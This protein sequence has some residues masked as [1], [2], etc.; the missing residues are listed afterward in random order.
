VCATAPGGA[1]VCDTDGHEIGLS[2]PAI[3][4]VKEADPISGTE[5]TVIT[6]TYTVTNSGDVPLT[7]VSVDDDVLGHICD[8]A[9]L[10]PQETVKCTGTYTIPPNS[11]AEITNIVVAGGTD[12]AGDL[13][14]DRDTFTITVVAGTV[15]TKTPPGGLAF[16]G[17]PATVIPLA[18][19]AIALLTLGS[20]MLWL[21]RRRGHIRPEDGQA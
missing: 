3:E 6:Y 12:P 16:T 5:G 10:Q 13:V 17:G 4:V 7:N 14:Q 15:V 2:H 18:V 20:A 9:V 1:T 19:A 21:G 11:R 8:I